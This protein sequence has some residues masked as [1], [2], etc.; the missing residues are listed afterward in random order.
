[1]E[2]GE[3]FIGMRVCGH[4][5]RKWLS[6]WEDWQWRGRMWEFWGISHFCFSGI[7]RD[8]R[9]MQRARRRVAGCI[10]EKIAGARSELSNVRFWTLPFSLC[11]QTTKPSDL[12][13]VTLLFFLGLNFPIL[14]LPLGIGICCCQSLEGPPSSPRRMTS[15][16]SDR[17]SNSWLLGTLLPNKVCLSVLAAIILSCWRQ[18]FWNLSPGVKNGNPL[19]YSCLRNPMDGGAWQAI[20][21]WLSKSQ[22]WLSS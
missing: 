17:N 4:R 19:Q 20:V 2:V 18:Q 16:H 8:D 21:H 22:T 15:C 13:L 3:T 7:N 5:W 9:H 11:W 1:M 10:L 12:R 14:F 6:T